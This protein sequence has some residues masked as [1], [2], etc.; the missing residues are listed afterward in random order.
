MISHAPQRMN[1]NFH[2][3]ELSGDAKVWL[4]SLRCQQLQPVEF[5]KLNNKDN[6]D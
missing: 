6:S 4:D 2:L 3:P 5:I 1:K